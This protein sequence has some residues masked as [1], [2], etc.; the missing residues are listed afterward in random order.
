M[1]EK[2]ADYVF[3]ACNRCRAESVERL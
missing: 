1:V 3:D 2:V